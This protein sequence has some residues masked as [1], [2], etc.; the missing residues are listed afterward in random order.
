MALKAAGELFA[1]S[2]VVQAVVAAITHPE[3]FGSKHWS[4]RLFGYPSACVVIDTA[5]ASY[6]GL[7]LY[8]FVAYLNILFCKIKLV[9][10][11]TTR[12]DEWTGLGMGKRIFI[13]GSTYVFALSVSTFALCWSISP[14]QSIYWHTAFFS[15]YL[16]ARWFAVLAS[17]VEYN[18]RI[19]ARNEI[20]HPRTKVKRAVYMAIYFICTIG[21]SACWFA[22]MVAGEGKGW[23]DAQPELE[24][25][26]PLI[27]WLVTCILDYGTLI[28]VALTTK[29]LPNNPV[30]LANYITIDR[31][32]THVAAG[33][34][35][36]NAAEEASAASSR[37]RDHATIDFVEMQIVHDKPPRPE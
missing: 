10:F 34:A 35:M 33:E 3:V 13:L 27:P 19:S 14:F 4:S 29:F 28:C 23:G 22:D 7:V 9:R 12:E 18:A 17:I 16:V 2:I 20:E 21:C 25:H 24:E 1:I 26:T 8:I 15:F 11:H 6:F 37:G 32:H 31:A 36:P 5:P 30:V